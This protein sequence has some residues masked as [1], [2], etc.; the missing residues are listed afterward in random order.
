M[1]VLSFPL[2]EFK[3][4]TMFLRLE[5]I[6]LFF[7][8]CSATYHKKTNLSLWLSRAP[9][10]RLKSCPHS[11][12]RSLSLPTHLITVITIS[13]HGRSKISQAMSARCALSRLRLES[14]YRVFNRAN[15][16]SWVKASFTIIVLHSLKFI[17]RSLYTLRPLFHVISR[18]SF[19][20]SSSNTV[21]T[22]SSIPHGILSLLSFPTTLVVSIDRR[23]RS[24]NST[25]LAQLFLKGSNCRRLTVC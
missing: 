2:I 25:V 1:V 10:N 20:H 4:A 8:N 14:P 21:S 12:D 11:I 13:F 23:N 9:I 18:N 15:L 7:A 6:F 22:S 16:F 5:A 19:F 24:G 3:S 17:L